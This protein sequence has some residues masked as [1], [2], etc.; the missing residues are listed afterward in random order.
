M[1]H[2]STSLLAH[3]TTRSRLAGL[4]AA[5]IILAVGAAALIRLAERPARAFPTCPTCISHLFGMVGIA[6]GQTARLNVFPIA[7]PTFPQG[8]SSTVML[9]FLDS[10]GGQLP[11]PVSGLPAQ[12]TLILSSGQAVSLDL[13]FPQAPTSI[14]PGSPPLLNGPFAAGGRVEIRAVVQISSLAADNGGTDIIA[15]LEVFDIA[16]GR[17]VVV[18]FPHNPD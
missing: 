14:P 3:I 10:N 11:D 6:P 9:S 7:A 8:S 4:T 12:T 5:A 2:K 1:K 17:T 16:T 18:L 15:N 13:A